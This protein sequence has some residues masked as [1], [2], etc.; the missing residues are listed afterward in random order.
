MFSQKSTPVVAQRSIFH[1]RAMGF[2]SL[3]TLLSCAECRPD[4][5]GA[6]G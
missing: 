1:L 3:Q 2:N 4:G 5:E 6:A